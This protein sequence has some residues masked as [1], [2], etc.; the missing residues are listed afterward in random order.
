MTT[1]TVTLLA[2]LA[3]SCVAAT[4]AWLSGRNHAAA[5]ARTARDAHQ[6]RIDAL[7]STTAQLASQLRDLRATL[8]AAHSPILVADSSGR[9]LLANPACEPFFEK[10]REALLGRTIE[11]LFTHAQVINAFTRARDGESADVQ[12]RH[13]PAGGTLHTYLVST[14]PFQGDQPRILISLRDITQVAAVSQLRSDFVAAASHELRTPLASIRAA[15]ETLADGAWEDPPMR[16][17]LVTITQSNIAR[18][19]NLLRDL[20]DLSHLEYNQHAAPDQTINFNDFLQ[21]LARD[22]EPLAAARNVSI[23]AQLPPNPITLAT[24]PRLLD[25]I[26][27]NLIDNATKF[28]YP[29]T[30]IRITCESPSPNSIRIHIIDQGA[31]IPLAH[32]QHI[33]ERFYQADAAR[34]GTPSN[35]DTAARRGTGL[36][37]ALARESA[38]ALGG[39]ISVQSIWKQGTTMTVELP[40]IPE[41]SPVT[42]A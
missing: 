16:D 32:Q 25:L 21:L 4:I 36:G 26:F 35:G 33:F 24:Q 30:T 29:N 31:G 11:N 37:L 22:F 28:A 7:A 15:A 38:V 1:A 6:G 40:R 2:I 17:R 10:T 14:L 9:I 19:E 3:C 41:A 39:T 27:R 23:A 20:L 42:L 13:A 8:D 5:N 12:I 18:L 34:T